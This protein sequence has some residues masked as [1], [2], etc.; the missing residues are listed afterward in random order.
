MKIWARKTYRIVVGIIFPIIYFF[1]P[2]KIP[3]EMFIA[4]LLGIMTTIEIIRK[5]APG[6]YS[7]LAAHSKGILKETTG[8]FMGTTA[9]LLAAFFIIAIFTK[10]VAILAILFLLFGDTASTIIGVRYGK[11]RFRWGKSLEGSL[12]FFITTIIISLLLM[13]PLHVTF[14]VALIGGLAETI[15]EA[16]PIKIDDNFT[17]G[18]GGAIVM[19]VMLHI[20]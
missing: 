20:L 11:L 16:L 9:Y 19:E 10:G 2:S 6:F 8:F 18:I 1:T 14:L 4:Y 17:V 15:I 5:V 13:K 7:T 3:V 12:A